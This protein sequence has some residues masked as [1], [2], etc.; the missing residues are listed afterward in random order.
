MDLI[1]RV[2]QSFSAADV[3]IFHD[4]K[5]PP[6]GGGNQ[7]L[8]ALRKELQARG[9][10]VENNTISQATRACL[11]NSYNFDFERLRRLRRRECRMVHRVD[12]PIGTYRGTDTEVDTRI[13]QINKEVADATIFQ[14]L[15]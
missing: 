10:R 14:S 4:F 12:G 11:F 8:L 5:R 1:R 15:Y 3:S 13:Q 2:T 9:L 6:Y 7:F